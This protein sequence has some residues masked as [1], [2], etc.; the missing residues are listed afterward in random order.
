MAQK[1]SAYCFEVVSV[2]EVVATEAKFSFH[3][4]SLSLCIFIRELIP[5]LLR[6]N[7]YK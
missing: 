6:N 1:V 4:N 5:L 7:N 2:F 3:N